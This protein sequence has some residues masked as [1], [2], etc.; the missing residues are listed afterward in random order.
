MKSANNKKK[1]SKNHKKKKTDKLKLRR[2]TAFLYFLAHNPHEVQNKKFLSSLL[3]PAQYTVLRELAVNELAG[4]IP[5][6]NREKKKS[7]LIKTARVRLTKLAKGQLTKS[8]LHH[9]LDL[10][11]ILAEHTVNYHDLC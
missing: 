6:L 5:P 1:S 9:I 8:N 7:S 2:E 4:N 11:K 3:E 10:I